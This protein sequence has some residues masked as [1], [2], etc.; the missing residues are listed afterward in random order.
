MQ[1]IYEILDN[2]RKAC[3]FLVFFLQFVCAL[4]PFLCPRWICSS[5][6]TDFFLLC[7]K[8]VLI[9]IEELLLLL[10]LLLLFRIIPKSVCE[11][12][13]HAKCILLET[14]QAVLK[15]KTEMIFFC[16]HSVSSIE[17]KRLN[18]DTM[19]KRKKRWSKADLC[20]FYCSILRKQLNLI[21]L[22]L[23][24]LWIYCAISAFILIK[25][26]VFNSN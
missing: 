16:F 21:Y 25:I 22:S 20:R 3:D 9:T 6:Q 11:R 23:E 18:A 1:A 10:L 15:E 19:Q 24:N 7:I 5:M 14:K 2:C 13:P 17:W 12:E 26:S 8:V 4:S